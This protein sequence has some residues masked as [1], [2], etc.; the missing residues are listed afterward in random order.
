MTNSGNFRTSFHLQLFTPFQISTYFLTYST[1]IYKT[2]GHV[3]HN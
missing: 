3:I 1:V 2:V